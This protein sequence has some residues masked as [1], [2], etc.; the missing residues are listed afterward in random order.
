MR[1]ID[2]SSS[3]SFSPISL[4]AMLLYCVCAFVF[5]TFEVQSF[6]RSRHDGEAEE[7]PVV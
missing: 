3:V 7:S 6:R 4:F 5:A 1:A 2:T